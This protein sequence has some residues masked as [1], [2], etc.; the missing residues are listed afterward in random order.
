MN[1]KT[2]FATLDKLMRNGYKRVSL[3][4]LAFITKLSRDMIIAELSKREIRLQESYGEFYIRLMPNAP[5]IQAHWLPEP[6]H[7]FKLNE[8]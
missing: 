6:K 4:E 8:K 2:I 3:S 7:T 1:D 5:V